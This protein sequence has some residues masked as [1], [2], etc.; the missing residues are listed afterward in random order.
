LAI[1][2]TYHPVGWVG[3]FSLPMVNYYLPQRLLVDGEKRRQRALKSLLIA[4]PKY[5]SLKKG[6]KGR[7]NEK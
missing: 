6:K 7:R 3:I 2:L 5:F 1:A 4:C